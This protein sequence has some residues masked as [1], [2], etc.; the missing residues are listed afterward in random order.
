MDPPGP[1]SG[2]P[3]EDIQPATASE[4]FVIPEFLGA[5]E[6]RRKV[7][8][9]AR[10]PPA[11]GFVARWSPLRRDQIRGIGRLAPV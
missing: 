2:V 9:R 11:H 8:S 4:A 10:S 1:V 5:K 3:R 7:G 6:R